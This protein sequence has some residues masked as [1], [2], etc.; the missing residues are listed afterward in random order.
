MLRRI[1]LS[2]L[3]GMI[4]AVSLLASYHTETSFAQDSNCADLS[5]HA[6][7]YN[8]DATL[9]WSRRKVAVRQ[10]IVYRNTH[11]EP[12]TELVFHSEPHRL[13]RIETMRF[14]NAYDSAGRFLA[15]VTME[16]MRLTVPLAEPVNVGC[17]AFVELVFDIN[18]HE[19]SD[20]NPLGWLA[21]TDKQIN[22][23]HWFPVIAPYNFNGNTGWYTT[24]RHYIGE[25]A[26]TDFADYEVN[27][28]L[29]NAPSHVV[30]VAPGS[31]NQINATQW[32][33]SHHGARDFGLSFSTIY[34]LNQ[35]QVG[36]VSVELYSLA[37]T[38]HGSVNQAL[39]D[40]TQALELYTEVYGDYPHDRLVIVEGDFP[41]G[42]ELSGMAFVSTDW[43]VGW[44]GQQLHWL[45]IITVHEI[46]HQWFYAQVGNDQ[47]NEP[48]LDETLATYSELLFYEHYYP[49]LVADWWQFR[50]NNYNLG[51]DAVDSTVYGYTNWRP[52]IN[53]VYFRGV[54]MLHEN[55][56]MIGEV[57]FFRWLADYYAQNNEQIATAEDFWQAMS[58]EN[59]IATASI[60][61]TY[62]TQPTVV[63]DE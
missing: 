26:V 47:A 30:L 50:I 8:L 14:H 5:G 4:I 43:F 58:P 25:Q 15:P 54:M 55:R 28:T 44:N 7:R 48:Y 32:H 17:D 11:P 46:A 51:T 6:T 53:T 52:Y 29:E 49:E 18:L 27:L 60:R 38:Y 20:S 24:Q 23:A 59:Y 13:S 16:E 21:Y 57:A 36:Q 37:T 56:L 63:A 22:L 39:Q 2:G 10:T 62:L 1:L 41:D 40:A 34:Q 3:M 19:L 45:T 42:L 12:L 33:I 61:T 31:V 9:D 35:Q